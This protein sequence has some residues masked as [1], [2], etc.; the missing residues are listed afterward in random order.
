MDGSTEATVSTYRSLGV[1]CETS[2]TPQ[3]SSY[4]QL[5]EERFVR[6]DHSTLAPGTKGSSM[7]VCRV[8]VKSR[9]GTQT[10]AENRKCGVQAWHRNVVGSSRKARAAGVHSENSQSPGPAEPEVAAAG[11][12]WLGLA[13][14]LALLGRRLLP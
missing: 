5:S 8:S 13:L 6:G 14:A 1:V 7:K 12:T 4:G 9:V 11:P 3:Q 10:E 2:I